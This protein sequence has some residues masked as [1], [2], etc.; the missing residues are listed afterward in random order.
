MLKNLTTIMVAAVANAFE[1]ASPLLGAGK[2]TNDVVVDKARGFSSKNTSW[3]APL[4]QK[5]V[6]SSEQD[7]YEKMFLALE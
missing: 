6:F 7:E 3:F 1:E 4:L 5:G 2:T